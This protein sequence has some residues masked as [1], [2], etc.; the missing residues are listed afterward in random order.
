MD[1]R[2]YLLKVSLVLVGFMTVCISGCLGPAQLAHQANLTRYSAPA[3]IEAAA[4][5]TTAGVAHAMARMLD[6][7]SKARL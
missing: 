5:Q 2:Y 6:I 3:R 4:W 1:R 7:V